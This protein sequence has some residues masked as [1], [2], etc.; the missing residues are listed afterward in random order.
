[1]PVGLNVPAVAPV[2]GQPRPCGSIA[3]PLSLRKPSGPNG[4]SFITV[5][6]GLFGGPGVV[7]GHLQN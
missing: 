4:K 7:I 6:V 1:M 5:S 2:L 3:V